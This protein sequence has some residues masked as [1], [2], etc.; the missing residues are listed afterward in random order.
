MQ[1]WIPALICLIASY[2]IFADQALLKKSAVKKFIHQ[3]VNQENFDQKQLK[4]ILLKAEYQEQIIASMER[5]FEKK[6]WDTYQSVFIT[7]KRI[8]GGLEFWLQNESALKAAEEKFKVPA[9]M[10]IAILGVETFYGE[11]Q[12]KYRVL[13]ALT[14]LAFYYPKRAPFFTK[15]LKEFLLLCREHHVPAEI[16]HGSYAGAMGKPQFMPSSYRYYGVQANPKKHIDLMNENADVIASVAN[17]LHKH[18]WQE[19]EPVIQALAR[20]DF[21]INDLEINTKY[22]NYSLNDLKQKGIEKLTP[23]PDHPPEKAGI[24]ELETTQNLEY[25]LAYP[26]FYVITRY[27]TS[28][29]YALVVYLLSNKLTEEKRIASRKMEENLS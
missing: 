25:F 10:I 6:P 24:I 5:P 13:D 14:T 17:Y 28:P 3:M 9:A 2:G 21:A 15:E 29:Q 4:S 12:G 26:N 18:G 8:A 7:P 20:A 19:N 27:N 22:A 1:R 11:Q 16:Y 23:I